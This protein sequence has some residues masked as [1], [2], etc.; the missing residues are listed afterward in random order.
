MI[1]LVG[2]SSTQSINPGNLAAALSQDNANDSLTVTSPYGN[3][4][5]NR[6]M[7]GTVNTTP[8]NPLTA[9]QSA[10]IAADPVASYV[11][12]LAKDSASVDFQYT[13]MGGQVIFH[14]SMPPNTNS[15]APLIVTVTNTVVTPAST[16]TTEAVTNTVVTPVK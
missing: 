2:C 16:T 3:A 13:G 15:T 14:R 8:V 7:P 9:A 6:S 11:L 10:A 5:L 4:V 12:G 1:A